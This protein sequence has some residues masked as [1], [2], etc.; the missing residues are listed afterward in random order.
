MFEPRRAKKSPQDRFRGSMNRFI[1]ERAAE[2]ALD[3]AQ[4]RI[5][6]AIIESTG[7]CC[8]TQTLLMVGAVG[9]TMEQ[10][11]EAFVRLQQNG[12]LDA[13]EIGTA[14]FEPMGWEENSATLTPFAAEVL[15][16]ELVEPKEE[17]PTS[18]PRWK[19]IGDEP[20][21]FWRKHGRHACEPASVRI[22][23]TLGAGPLD[24]MIEEEIRLRRDALRR[25]SRGKRKSLR[26]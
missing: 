22:H 14:A 16:L 4:L 8:S 25:A 26:E 5:L 11:R 21:S 1:E 9:A 17:R 18:K 19:Y 23:R 7:P 3:G 24:R 2:N 6:R 15:G 10:S 12:W 20:A 13:W